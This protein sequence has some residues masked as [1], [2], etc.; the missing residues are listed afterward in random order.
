MIRRGEYVRV[1]LTRD[2]YEDLPVMDAA[3]L[4][5]RRKALVSKFTAGKLIRLGTPLE[6]LFGVLKGRTIRWGTHFNIVGCERLL[7]RSHIL[8]LKSLTN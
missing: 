4:L 8:Q 2:L 3:A 6:N 7:I 1:E 5:R